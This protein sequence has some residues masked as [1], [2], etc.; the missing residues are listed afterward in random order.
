M[1][2][3]VAID[4]ACISAVRV[5]MDGFGG[6]TRRAQGACFTALMG[7]NGVFQARRILRAAEPGL[8]T[9]AFVA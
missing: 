5:R 3:D 6:V 9:N 1:C 4:R 7:L 8:M 2:P